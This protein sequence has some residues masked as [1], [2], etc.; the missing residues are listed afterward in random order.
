[1]HYGEGLLV[2]SLQRAFLCGV[3]FAAF[4]LPAIAQESLET[5]VVTGIRSSLRDSLTM[6]QNSPLITDNISTKDIGQL[7]DITI[8]EELNRLPGVNT[9]RDRG[10]ASQVAIRGLGPRFVF[11][12]VNG[13]EVA[14][15]EPTQNVRYES[16][17][18]EILSGA[19]VYKTQDASL[20]A[21]GIA[22]TIDIRTA[23][24]LE[25]QGPM[26]AL[27]FGPSYNSEADNL[28][29]YDG[30]GFRGSAA[31]NYHVSDNFAFSLAASVQRQKNGYPNLVFWTENTNQPDTGWGNPANLTGNAPTKVITMP[32]GATALTGGNPAPWGAN[33]EV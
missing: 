1:M 23:L 5:V 27:R 4:V 24:P 18:S 25:Y 22:A 13:R 10:N 6:K 15:S 31:F 3:S 26:L 30:L 33:T 12:L 7:P 16:Y 8:G 14:S 32:N 20:I 19:Q 21:G 29:H 28:P 11:G 17:P 9:Q 2:K